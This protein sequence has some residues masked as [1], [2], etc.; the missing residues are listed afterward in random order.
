MVGRFVVN[1]NLPTKGDFF[2]YME[3][4]R[5]TPNSLDQRMLAPEGNAGSSL[6]KRSNVRDVTVEELRNH[7]ISEEG[8]INLNELR[9]GYPH[10]EFTETNDQF[11]RQRTLKWEF[12]N[13][14]LENQDIAQVACN[15]ETHAV[16]FELLK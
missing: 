10:L 4:F 7:G 1:Y 9:S 2:V 15:L 11:R 16:V 3:R 14:L 12:E 8:I 13:R 6:A 5:I